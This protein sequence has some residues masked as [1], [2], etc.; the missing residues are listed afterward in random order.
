MKRIFGAVALAG[1]ASMFAIV[2]MLSHAAGTP[3]ASASAKPTPPAG[4]QTQPLAPADNSGKAWQY[5]DAGNTK[6]QAGS[7]GSHGW[8][9]TDANSTTKSASG[10]GYSK[11]C[12][13]KG[14]RE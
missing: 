9:T 13:L 12:R 10:E 6:A 7:A 5:H 8:M 4:S 3:C 2:P 11:D 14:E 1:V